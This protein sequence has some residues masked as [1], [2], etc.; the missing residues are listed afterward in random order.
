MVRVVFIYSY[1]I[2]LVFDV[3]DYDRMKGKIV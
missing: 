1:D 2:V 3:L